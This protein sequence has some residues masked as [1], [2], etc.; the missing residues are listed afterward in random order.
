MNRLCF[1]IKRGQTLE[2]GKFL[3]HGW[4]VQHD[5]VANDVHFTRNQ[6]ATRHQMHRVLL[7]V[8][9]Q[10]VAGIVA[11]VETRHNVVPVVHENDDERV[12]SV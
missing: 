8:H 1:F 2:L 7:T 4:H 9:H 6:N 3:E 10:C 11:A 5:P 12:E